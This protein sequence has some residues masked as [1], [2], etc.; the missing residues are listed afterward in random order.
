M[1]YDFVPTQSPD[2]PNVGSVLKG[3]GYKTAYFG[4]FEMDKKIL[5]W[6]ASKRAIILLGMDWHSR[7]EDADGRFWI[8]PA[9]S[10]A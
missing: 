3:L 8:Q 9:G 4:K 1:P 6:L 2:I 5:G 7:L 10:F